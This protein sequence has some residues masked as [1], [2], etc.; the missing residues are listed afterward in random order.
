MT[1]G[2]GQGLIYNVADDDKTQQVRTSVRENGSAQSS[3]QTFWQRLKM[4]FSCE[5]VLL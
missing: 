3:F 2:A 5:T 4:P 1:A